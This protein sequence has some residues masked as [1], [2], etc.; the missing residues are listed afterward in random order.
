MNSKRKSHQLV[1]VG[2][3]LSGGKL[4]KP[5]VIGTYLPQHNHGSPAPQH[6][7]ARWAGWMPGTNKK[8]KPCKVW[9]EDRR[10]EQV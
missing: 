10:P 3:K 4:A 9:V 2:K 6:F 5:H 7:D 8:G 1:K